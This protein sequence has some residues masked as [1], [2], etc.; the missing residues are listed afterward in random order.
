MA[1]PLL[2]RLIRFAGGKALDRV[3]TRVLPGRKTAGSGLAK[4]GLAKGLAGA[5]MARIATR[6]VPGA[7]VVGGGLLAKMLYDRRH[8]K[9][10]P[11]APSAQKPATPEDEDTDAIG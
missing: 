7:I 5:A 1:L 4:G 2:A 3:V 9:A 10:G 11:P 8:A 6:S